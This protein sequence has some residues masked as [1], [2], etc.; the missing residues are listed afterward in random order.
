VNL[1]PKPHRKYRVL[2][3]EFHLLENEQYVNK[4][5]ESLYHKYI[6]LYSYVTKLG[7]YME[8]LRQP[9]NCFNSRRYGTLIISAPLRPF[10]ISEIEKLRGDVENTQLSLVVFGEWQEDLTTARM[11]NKLLKPYFIE[12]G[13]KVYSGEYSFDTSPYL[14][15]VTSSTSIVRFPKNAFLISGN[16]LNEV[17]A[18]TNSSNALEDIGVFGFIPRVGFL[19]I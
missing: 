5:R 17:T 11:I 14:V 7:Y 3:D 9:W 6:K 2:W 8:I 15:G 18:L 16:L 1:I 12:L 4:Y 13:D 10:G 19:L